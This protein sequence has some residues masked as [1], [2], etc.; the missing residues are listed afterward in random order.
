MTGLSPLTALK[1]V[2]PKRAAI[3]EAEG[4]ASVA[5]LFDYFPRRYLDRRTI[6]SVRELHAGE[7]VT[8]VGTIRLARLEGSQPRRMRFKA[9]L[10]DGS[11]SLELT[12][13]RGV[14]YFVS[15]VAPGDAL[16]VHG[17]VGFF[18][19]QAQMQHPDYEHLSGGGGEGR[20]D[21][22]LFHT[23]RIIPIYS[24][25]AAMKQGGLGSRQLRTI[26]ARAFDRFPPGREE[27]L[28]EELIRQ[29]GLL[30]LAQAYRE[31]HFPSSQEGLEAARTRMK[32]T[33]LFYTQLLFALRHVRLERLRNACRFTRSGELTE[34][35]YGSLPFE[36]TAAQKQVI[37]EIYGDLRKEKPM[38]RLLQGDVGSGKTLVAMFAIALAADN[39]LQSAF[40]APTEILAVQHYLSLKRSMEPLGICVSLLAGRQSKKERNT[41]L[42]AL[43]NGSVTVAVGT[44]AMIEK[45][46]SFSRLGL[47]IIDEQHR[48]GVLQRKA[49]QDKA[50]SPHVLLMTATPIPR[51]LTMA[52]FGDLDVSVIDGMPAGRV[53]VKTVLV[54]EQAK[55]RVY[56]LLRHEVQ[57][58]RQAYIVYPL[59]EASE[60]IDL[61]A[62]V[63][64]FG[65]L[66][67]SVLGDLRLGLIHGQMTP[68]EKDSVMDRFRSGDLDVLVGTTVIEVGVDVPNASVMVIEH[69]ERFGLAQLHQLRGRVGRGRHASSC[70]LVHASL[71]GEAGERLR[72]METTFDGF[73]ISEI[74]AAIR[75]AGN[76]LGREQSGM[77]SGLK[78]ADPLLDAP[79]MQSARQA[80]F[81]LAAEDPELRNREHALIKSCYL[82][83][84]HDRSPLADIG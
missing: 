67:S 22:D 69:A 20:S 71:A 63:E 41:V 75:G 80:A 66:S 44:H 12:W 26:V 13:F 74:D 70:F 48:F 42:E 82:R 4:I 45:A 37:R 56:D 34:R 54:P 31:M 53:P 60:K 79:L 52:G 49:L 62:A 51:T 25:S 83:H 84:Y 23:G 1:G 11:G 36:L 77:V 6:R 68:E 29:H 78:L 76:V 10:D 58:G 5:D 17:R 19:R 28:P 64:S 8:V 16:A 35:F 33:E 30:T 73:R 9:M 32:W 15:D 55:D 50:E 3:L 47:V 46:V 7:L 21:Y 72:A 14:R 59:V 57:S 40:M 81:A 38:N 65:E 39:G 18:G 61:R 27:T 43:E 2:G 24:T